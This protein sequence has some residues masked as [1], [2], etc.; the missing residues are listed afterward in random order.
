MFNSTHGTKATMNALG[1]YRKRQQPTTTT[2]TTMTAAGGHASK[3]EDNVARQSGIPTL[4]S[5]PF[6]DER[7]L[8]LPLCSAIAWHD[9]EQSRTVVVH[10]IGRAFVL[11]VV[12]IAVVSV[13]STCSVCRA[14]FTFCLSTVVVALNRYLN[15]YYSCRQVANKNSQSMSNQSSESDFARTQSSL[16]D[17]RPNVIPSIFVCS[18]DSA[19]LSLSLSLFVCVFVTNLHQ[20][21]SGNRTQKTTNVVVIRQRLIIGFSVRQ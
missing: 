4:H 20:A 3:S 19:M 14:L 2:T 16:A 7:R 6:H 18:R 13:S 8:S 17:T 15:W 12:V 9:T 11:D 1:Q 10:V 21:L 5:S